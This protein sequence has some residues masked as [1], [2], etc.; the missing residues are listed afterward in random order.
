[1]RTLTLIILRQ[2]KLKTSFALLVL[3]GMASITSSAQT[4]TTLANFNGK[5]GAQPLGTLIQGPTG[6]TLRHDRIG[7]IGPSARGQRF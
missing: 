5:N 7:T 4:F 2:A 6:K 1:M 3:Y